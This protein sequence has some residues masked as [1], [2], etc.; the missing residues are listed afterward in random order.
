VTEEILV[1]GN[2]HHSAVVKVGDT[3][4][5]PTGSWT[6]NVHQLL[7]HLETRGFMH[8]PRVLG[9][10]ERQREILSF[11]PGVVIW[12]DHFDRVS[13]DEALRDVASIIRSFHD[14]VADLPRT[15]DEIWA[16]N[17]RDPANSNEVVCHNDFAPWNLI[18]RPDGTWAFIDWDLAAPGRRSWD[19][20]WALLNFVPLMPSMLSEPLSDEAI[21]RR[22]GFFR[23]AYGEDIYPDDVLAIA[24]ERCSRETER[25]FRLGAAGEA[26][27][28][29]LMAKG[30]G[31][32]WAAAAAHV[33]A[34]APRWRA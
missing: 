24:A 1:G 32:I 31:E 6:A 34:A 27:Y 15:G 25:I 33:R 18:Q 23:E 2:T 14:A 26:P 21:R 19:I 8:A 13:S 12:P 5:R 9:V 29:R 4:R 3:V 16:D 20:S 7:R 10:D 30:H 11:V 28:T 22:L 17:G